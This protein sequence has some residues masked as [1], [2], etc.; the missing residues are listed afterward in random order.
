MEPSP[1][2]ALL[3]DTHSAPAP[4]APPA[5]YEVRLRRGVGATTILVGHDSAGEPLVEL[6]MPAKLVTRRV[7]E[8]M[9]KFCR[10]A[11]AKPF[12]LIR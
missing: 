9:E 2:L 8:R 10:F 1:S 12:L 11:A 5:P 7:I 6:R 4:L 3:P